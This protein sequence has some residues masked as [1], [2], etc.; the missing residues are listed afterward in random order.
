MRSLLFA[1]LGAF[2]ATSAWAALS[3]TDVATIRALMDNAVQ[4]RIIRDVPSGQV[5]QIII[6]ISDGENRKSAS[7]NISPTDSEFSNAL[8][9]IKAV[10]GRRV[11]TYVNQIQALGVTVTP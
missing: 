9:A 1:L 7:I 2:I 5:S 4:A 11:T 3:E 10:A 8:T 6:T